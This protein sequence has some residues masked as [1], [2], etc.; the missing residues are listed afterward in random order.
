[1]NKL[2]TTF[3]IALSMLCSIGCSSANPNA[4]IVNS[5]E[6]YK[7]IADTT[8]LCID[9]VAQEGYQKGKARPAIIFFF[10][11]G[12]NNGTMEQFRKQAE[13]FATR[14]FTCFLVD[15]RTKA[16][17]KVT[18][19][20]CL[21]DAKSAVRYIVSNA[22]RF[23]I[24]TN[25]MITSGGSAGGHLAAAVAMCPN[26]NDPMDDTSIS[27]EMSALLLFNPVVCN[28]PE[29]YNYG[30]ERVSDYYEDFSP[31]HNV[32]EGATPT[33]LFML[34]SEDN[35]IPEEMAEDF[36]GLYEAAGGSC[37]VIIYE[38]KGHGFFNGRYAENHKNRDLAMFIQTLKDSEQFLRDQGYI[39]GK[40]SAEE[41]VDE[42]IKVV[43]PEYEPK[44]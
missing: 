2:I 38:G 41:M 36:K 10:G 11:G 17:H 8:A 22:K 21:M 20:V 29:E 12:W 39:K 31:M 34:G 1:M 13:Y 37:K 28:G 43:Y 14:G 19:D 42:W 7:Q 4:E 24:N 3:A 27:T 32:R 26:I 35:L 6:E 15:Y 44:N 33:A 23:N 9:I 18:P 30:Y 5:R 25:K 40:L 16:S